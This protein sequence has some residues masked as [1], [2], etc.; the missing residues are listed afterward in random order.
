[1]S[2]HSPDQVERDCRQLFE[3]AHERASQNVAVTDDARPLR[4]PAA[5]FLADYERVGALSGKE[6]CEAVL[7]AIERLDRETEAAYALYRE[8]FADQVRESFEDICVRSV[9]FLERQDDFYSSIAKR[10]EAREPS[11]TGKRFRE[12]ATVFLADVDRIRALSGEE[13]IR[14]ADAAVE[15]F[16]SLNDMKT[17]K[18]EIREDWAATPPLRRWVQTLRPSKR[19]SP[20][21]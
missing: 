16:T 7:A 4:D 13:F 2:P 21:P 20:L 5:S 11:P 9:R 1:M 12:Q 19:R 10:G 14:E 15:A 6:F 17:V 3:S 18:A 8:Q